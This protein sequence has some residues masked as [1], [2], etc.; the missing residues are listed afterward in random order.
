V[1]WKVLV[2]LPEMARAVES[3]IRHKEDAWLD[4]SPPALGG[5]TPRQAAS[6]P[7]RR[8]DL[9]SLL[10]EF[11]GLDDSGM[12]GFDVSRLRDRLGLPGQSR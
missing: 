10:V 9:E 7:T 6:D 2:L 8:E 3:L 1:L 5:L 12:I 4:E 11:E